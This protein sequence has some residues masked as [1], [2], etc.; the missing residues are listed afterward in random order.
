MVGATPGPCRCSL[1]PHISLK[2]P[3]AQGK[4]QKV[5]V[6]SKTNCSK[7]KKMSRAEAFA[8]NRVLPNR[9]E[10]RTLQNPHVAASV[11]QDPTQWKEIPVQENLFGGIIDGPSIKLPIVGRDHLIVCDYLE[12]DMLF[13]AKLVDYLSSRAAVRFFR[14]DNYSFFICSDADD[15]TIQDAMRYAGNG[16]FGNHTPYRSYVMT[17]Q[18]KV[19]L[20]GNI[21]E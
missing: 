8:P 16:V 14:N 2:L 7:A 9:I 4:G 20:S 1:N 18:G 17:P 11:T 12:A 3:G 19:R 15:A 21:P 10:L 6:M 5:H 13:M